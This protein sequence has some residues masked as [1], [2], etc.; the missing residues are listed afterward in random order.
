MVVTSKKS[1]S[2]SIWLLMSRCMMMCQN[3]FK[4][5]FRRSFERM[6]KKP[7]NLKQKSIKKL[8]DEW[9]AANIAFNAK[10]VK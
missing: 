9:L 1:I 2:L 7:L 3:D 6:V 8:A 4:R 10:W 5:V